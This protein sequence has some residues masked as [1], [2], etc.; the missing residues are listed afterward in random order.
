M[1]AFYAAVEQRD[2]PELRGKPVIVGADPRGG[3]GRGVVATAS[4][5]ARRFG[6]ASAMPISQACRLCPQGVYVP[7]DMEKYARVSAEVM[8]MLRDFTDC[9]EPISIDEAFLDVTA[10]G[11]VLGD[12][13]DDRPRAQG[14]RCA[15][16][17][18]LDGLGGRRR[19]ASSWPR[20]RPTCASRT[21]WWWCRAGTEAAFLAPLPV[22][23]LWGVG[24]K[25]EEGAGAAGRRA[26]SATWPA[27]DREK[28]EQPP[29]HPRPRPG[30]PGPR[31]GR[32]AGGGRAERR[33]ERGPRAHVRHRHRRPRACCAA[34]CWSC[35]T[36]WPGACAQHR[37]RA[38]TVT[39]KYRDETFTHAH[40]RRDAGGG[41][42][43][44]RRAVRHRLGA[45]REDA[46]RAARAPPG[47][48]RVGPGRRAAAGPVRGRAER[49]AT[50]CATR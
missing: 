36:R 40:A 18:Q 5:E 44:G 14:P 38:R 28:L 22:R 12:A 19:L 29:G 7:P 21:G 33:Q 8:E 45:L 10:A 26:P 2:R 31:R 39:L 27:L 42:R 9:V 47:R 32:A 37:V 48:V 23:R 43:R 35:A 46:R 24:P 4:Y 49:R 3:R 17:R 11:R 50:A 15:R 25:T 13:P 34:R 20:S 41:H 1:D 6:V 16:R 30:A